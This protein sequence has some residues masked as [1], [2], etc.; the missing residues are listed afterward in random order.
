MGSINHVY[1]GTQ[2]KV[3]VQC[4]N[5][6]ND[7][8]WGR[9]Y[10][11]NPG[12]FARVY[13]RG[14]TERNADVKIQVWATEY[15]NSSEE[16]QDILVKWV[17]Y[18]LGTDKS[19][20]VKNDKVYEQKGGA[21]LD[22]VDSNGSTKNWAS[23]IES[24]SI[25]DVHY[26][27]LDVSDAEWRP[28]GITYIDV[29][30][31]HQEKTLLEGRSTLTF[32]ESRAWGTK[33]V[34]KIGAKASFEA[35]VPLIGKTKFTVSADQSWENNTNDRITTT[36]SWAVVVKTQINAD[37]FVTMTSQCL[38]ANIKVPYTAKLKVL[39]KNGDTHECDIYGVF[40]GV[41]GNKIQLNISKEMDYSGSE[42]DLS[43]PGIRLAASSPGAVLAKELPVDSVQEYL[44]D[45]ETQEF[46][47]V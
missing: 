32:Q 35:G 8:H 42:G 19:W 9:E 36:R 10:V 21:G 5:P 6:D 7:N 46:V 23:E 4:L 16:T 17:R 11:L 34:T 3:T 33:T 41:C 39:Y 28:N 13:E 22:V 37:K 2:L 12:E 20:I 1:N 31:Q 18:N 29:E 26:S 30:N 40:G 44:Y 25:T 45:E 15:K 43:A 27:P 47:P 38:Q 24:L 14:W